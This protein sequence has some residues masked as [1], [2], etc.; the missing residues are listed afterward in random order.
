MKSPAF[1]WRPTSVAATLLS[2]I[3]RR[4]GAITADRM[5]EPGARVGAPVVC[6]GNFVAGGAGKT[7][8]AIWLARRL[9]E[10]GEIPFLLSRGYGGSLA[11][12][13]RVDPEAHGAVEVGDEP[14]LLAL[15]APTVV[16][17]DRVAGAKAAVEAGAGVIVLD[18]GLQNPSLV[19]DVALV[20]VDA[21]QGVGNGR[22]LPAGPLRAPLDRQLAHADAVLVIG[23]GA[24]GEA[25]ARLA[26]AARKPVFRGAIRP[27]PAVAAELAGRRVLAVAG[28]GRP[29]KLAETLRGLGAEVVA[30]RALADHALP[31]EREADAI[32]AAARFSDA[33]IVTTA[34]DMVKWRSGRPKLYAA[35]TAL[36]IDLAVTEADRLIDL[37]R[38]ALRRAGD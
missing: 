6:V 1:W 7:P 31:S 22:C 33:R 29:E 14:L 18:D 34:K 32:L 5:D 30:L 24:A 12:P 13:V 16:A 10:A 20:V 35:A 38:A 21:A 19:K 37:V 28:L 36:P 17:R 11:G 8:T 2:P 4:V 25:V 27:E 3:G 15:A 23:E 26:A 9:A